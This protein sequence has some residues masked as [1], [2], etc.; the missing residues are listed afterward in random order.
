LPNGEEEMKSLD[1]WRQSAVDETLTKLNVV[2]IEEIQPY[3]YLLYSDALPRRND[4]R[5]RDRILKRYRHL[6]HGGWWCSGINV[7]TGE[8]DLWGCFKPIKPQRSR[9]DRKLIK[10]EHPPKIETGI[11]ALRV[12]LHIWRRIADRYGVPLLST[13]IIQALP[14]FGFWSWVLAHREIP[15]VLCEG[16]KKA[17]ALLSAGYCAIAL[18]GIFNAYHTPNDGQGKQSGNP[19]LIP[20]LKKFAVPK[21]EIYLAFD[22]DTKQKTIAHVHTAVKR[23]GKLLANA[24]CVVKV[25]QWD[26]EGGLCKGCDDLI[27]NH[28]SGSRL[29]ECKELHKTYFSSQGETESAF[30]GMC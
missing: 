27:I 5:L 21:R 23:T 22:Q 25:I 26:S 13:D 14:D 28:G 10:Y 29:L 17:G 12:P 9:D 16:A 19:F 2:D 7:L 15:V 3:E 6:E 1:E 4:G 30:P 8:A 11:F 20:H 24:G 18:P